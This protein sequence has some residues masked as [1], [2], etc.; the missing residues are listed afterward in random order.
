[1]TSSDFRQQG[2]GRGAMV[3]PVGKRRSAMASITRE[4]LIDASP[5]AVWDAVSDFGAVHRRFAPGFVTD[6]VLEPGARLVTFAD[7]T[8][9]RELFLGC[10]PRRRRLAYAVRSERLSH[11]SAA[12]EV[13]EAADGRARLVWTTDVLPEAAAGYIAGRMEAGLEAARAV[14]GRIPA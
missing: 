6:V 4:T 11:H 7:G 12:F 8:V 3:P 14:V 2:R 13:F 5:D 1:V 10:D 9:V